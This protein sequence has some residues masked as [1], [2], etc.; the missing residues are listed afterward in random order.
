MLPFPSEYLVVI[1]R[2]RAVWNYQYKGVES[3]PNIDRSGHSGLT[4]LRVERRGRDETA[5]ATEVSVVK[6]KLLLAEPRV[7]FSS[8]QGDCQ[9][10]GRRESGGQR[11]PTRPVRID[12]LLQL[13]QM[14]W[15]YAY[16]CREPVPRF[17]TRIVELVCLDEQR[18]RK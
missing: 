6:I 9:C 2:D 13:I 17:T 14:Y 7:R 5:R 11:G 1:H 12:C 10:P 4:N 16:R 15:L 3:C 8:L 18:I